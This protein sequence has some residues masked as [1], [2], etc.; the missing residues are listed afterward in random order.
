MEFKIYIDTQPAYNR[1][2][3]H[4]VVFRKDSKEVLSYKDGA[5]I[6][7]IVEENVVSTPF[8]SLPM[9]LFKSIEEK[10]ILDL[11]RRGG[12][13]SQQYMRGRCEQLEKEVAWLRTQVE[14]IP[15]IPKTKV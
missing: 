6:S 11:E 3:I 5:V 4:A 7:S 1:V 10:I 15:F 13:P 8:I 9:E 2:D 14:Q 12:A